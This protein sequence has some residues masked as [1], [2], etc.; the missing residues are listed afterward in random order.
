M[1]VLKRG[2]GGACLQMHFYRTSESYGPSLGVITDNT[3]WFTSVSVSLKDGKSYCFLFGKHSVKSKREI[4]PQN[5]DFI[6][7]VA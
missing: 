3:V 5:I 7:C 6:L 2:G 1:T 4:Y